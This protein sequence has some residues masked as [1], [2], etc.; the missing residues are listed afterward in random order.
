MLLI[1]LASPWNWVAFVV[2]FLLGWGEVAVYWRR[3]RE[4][5]VQAGSET[6]IG[7]RGRVV[8]PLR[9]L[10]QVMIDGE[11]WEARS[12]GGA[13]VGDVVKVVSRDGLVLVVEPSVRDE[14]LERNDGKPEQHV[15]GD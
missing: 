11:R 4:R 12:P 15:H 9:P 3:V 8:A 5:R 2:C 6:L 1:L 10:G 7:K 14:G 13:A